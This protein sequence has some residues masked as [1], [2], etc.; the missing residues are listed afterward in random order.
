M[1]IIYKTLLFIAIVQ[2]SECSLAI[3][4]MQPFTECTTTPVCSGPS[5]E[6][7][8]RFIGTQGENFDRQSYDLFQYHNAFSNTSD[9]NILILSGNLPEFGYQMTFPMVNL[10]TPTLD[11]EWNSILSQNLTNANIFEPQIKLAQPY[12]QKMQLMLNLPEFSYIS[13]PLERNTQKQSHELTP[14]ISNTKKS[15]M[16]PRNIHTYQLNNCLPSTKKAIINFVNDFLA[17]VSRWP[18]NECYFFQCP[19]NQKIAKICKR[20]CETKGMLSP[21]KMALAMGSNSEFVRHTLC[22]IISIL[23]KSYN[24][25]DNLISVSLNTKDTVFSSKGAFY[26]K[27]GDYR[28]C[29]QRKIVICK[30]A[31]AFPESSSWQIFSKLVSK[32]HRKARPEVN[33]TLSLLETYSSRQQMHEQIYKM[34]HVS[35]LSKLK[36]GLVKI[37][38]SL[39]NS[40]ST[41]AQKS[42]NT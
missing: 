4:D 41:I 6:L 36:Q 1:N 14:V 23:G 40:S 25:N 12:A 26:Q 11:K 37:Y 24:V 32:N 16:S 13:H 3:M 30:Y 18:K 34:S 38:H 31:I 15:T 35:H 17:G 42:A 28:T 33:E 20:Y 9:S 2:Y 39:Q 7:K 29:Y 19:E 27:F 10:N 21:R 8:Y 5:W 22:D